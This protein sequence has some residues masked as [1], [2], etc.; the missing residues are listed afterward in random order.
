[1]VQQAFISS[2]RLY[3]PVSRHQIELENTEKLTPTAI[4]FIGK[5]FVQQCPHLMTGHFKKRY[6]LHFFL[7][8]NHK[9]GP[10]FMF[11]VILGSGEQKSIFRSV[12]VH[13]K[14]YF[15]WFFRKSDCTDTFEQSTTMYDYFGARQI[16]KLNHLKANSPSISEHLNF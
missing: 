14:Q 7:S 5:H 2:L 10:I 1:M 6:R 12:C 3:F 13:F 16:F 9:S 15:I 4:I 8:R 11:D